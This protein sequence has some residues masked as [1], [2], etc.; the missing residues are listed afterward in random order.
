MTGEV[1]IRYSSSRPAGVGQLAG[2]P[3]ED[4]AAFGLLQSA[5]LVEQVGAGDD[6][7]RIPR[8][9]VDRFGGD[10][11]LG[12][13]VDVVGEGVTAPGGPGLCPHLCR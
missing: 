12:D 11:I 9:G 5:D 6:H 1:H 13:R 4:V 3:D 2:A 10:D 8:R 7:G